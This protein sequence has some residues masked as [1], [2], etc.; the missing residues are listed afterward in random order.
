MSHNFPCSPTSGRENNHILYMQNYTRWDICD[1]KLGGPE[2]TLFMCKLIDTP[3]K[4]LHLQIVRG[5]VPYVPGTESRGRPEEL[6]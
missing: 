3:L 6:Q 2:N 1:K 5:V 4:V